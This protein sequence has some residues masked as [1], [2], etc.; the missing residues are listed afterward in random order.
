MQC[1][2]K[3]VSPEWC[4]QTNT[5]Y[6]ML[7]STGHS[8]EAIN[9]YKYPYPNKLINNTL[10]VYSELCMTKEAQMTVVM[11]VSK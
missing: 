10:A 1:F 3:L 5:E 8:A 4:T 6:I 2:L 7:H 9:Q 11:L